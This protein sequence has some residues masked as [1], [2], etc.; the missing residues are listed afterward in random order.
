MINLK[1]KFF[2]NCFLIL[3][4]I[5]F[6]F[7]FYFSIIEVPWG[8]ILLISPDYLILSNS[9]FIFQTYAGHILIVPHLLEYVSL[10]FFNGSLKFLAF[11]FLGCY[12]IN[13]IIMKTS[14]RRLLFLHNE[15][16]KH[17]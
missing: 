3:G 5:S 4:F 12:L 13:F 10:Y 1:L 7:S 15:F 14:Y 2:V 17:P 6:I 8:D 16:E 11:I 9:D